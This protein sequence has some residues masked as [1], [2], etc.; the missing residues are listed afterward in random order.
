MSR[1]QNTLFVTAIERTTIKNKKTPKNILQ[2]FGKIIELVTQNSYLCNQIVN[3]KNLVAETLK[4]TQINY[5]SDEM[6]CVCRGLIQF[7]LK[8]KL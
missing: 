5:V 2:N 3:L 4:P 7:L 1:Y 6:K 8:L